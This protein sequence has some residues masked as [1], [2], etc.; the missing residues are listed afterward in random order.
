VPKKNAVVAK[1]TV[2][3]P[4]TT[5]EENG[6]SRRCS[7]RAVKGKKAGFGPL[8]VEHRRPG[9]T[10]W[11][12]SVTGLDQEDVETQLRRLESQGCVIEYNEFF[13]PQRAKRR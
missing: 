9:S 11:S 7:F 8:S 10:I 6:R 4:V 3:L 2:K 1:K 12:L 13:Q 5:P